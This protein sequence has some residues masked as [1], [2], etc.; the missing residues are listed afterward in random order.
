[1]EGLGTGLRF[2][3]ISASGGARVATS[4]SRDGARE[5]IDLLLNIDYRLAAGGRKKSPTISRDDEGVSLS[6][7]RL[8]TNARRSGKATSLIARSMRIG[9]P[10]DIGK[11][12]VVRTVIVVYLMIIG[13][14]IPI[15]KQLRVVVTPAGVNGG[16][17]AV[18][19]VGIEAAVRQKRPVLTVDDFTR[20][21]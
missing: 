2:N 7:D 14:R 5:T 21:G 19:G 18:R 9:R 20:I 8:H 6:R 17:R 13:I 3:A 10:L 1:M 12:R 16:E 4:P 11:E 15:P